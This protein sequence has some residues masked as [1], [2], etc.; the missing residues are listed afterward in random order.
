MKYQCEVGKKQ[1]LKAMDKEVPFADSH[2]D[3]PIKLTSE[4]MEAEFQEE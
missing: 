4:M 1:T 2:K 3:Y